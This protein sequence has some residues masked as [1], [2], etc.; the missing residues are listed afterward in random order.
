MARKFLNGVAI[1]G[2]SPAAGKVLVSD[3]SGNGSWGDR[4]ADII[5]VAQTGTRVTGIGDVLVGFYV[6]RAFV[7]QSVTYQF[8]TADAS[9]STSVELGRN[10]SQVASSNLTVSA[11]NQADGTG[12]DAARTASPTQAFSVGDRLTVNVTA[13]GTTPGK[14]LIAVLRGRYT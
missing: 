2:G 11:A 10:G 1:P 9:G 13:V 4:A 7:L 3:A 14:Q 12:T 5:I 8:G 6:T